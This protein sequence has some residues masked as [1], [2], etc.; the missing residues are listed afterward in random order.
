MGEKNNLERRNESEEGMGSIDN[1]YSLR[2]KREKRNR[3]SGSGGDVESD[4]WDWD[5]WRIN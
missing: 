1:D 4:K 3:S 5:C 2:E